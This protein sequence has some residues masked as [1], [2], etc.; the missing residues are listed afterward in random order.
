MQRKG[1]RTR[2]CDLLDIDYPIL[3]AP[4]QFIATPQLVA[5]VCEA[6]G[7]GVLAGIGIPPDELRRH[8]R[9]TRARTERPFGVNLLLHSAIRPPL[10]P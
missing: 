6:G 3:Q 7:M 10:D 9:E 5:A 1:F 4:M 2:L 8:I